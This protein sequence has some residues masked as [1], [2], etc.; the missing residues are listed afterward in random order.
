MPRARKGS[1][2]KPEMTW[3]QQANRMLTSNYLDLSSRHAVKQ[4]RGLKG[5]ESTGKIH[6]L[7]TLKKYE[8]SLAKAGTWI[9]QQFGVKR[10]NHITTQQAKAYLDYRR[11]EVGQKQLS[12]DRIALERCRKVGTLDR[13]L[14]EVKSEKTGRAYKP[15]QIDRIAKRQAPHNRLA[16]KI[17]YAAGLRAKELQTLKRAEDG[18]PSHH[19]QWR[20]DRFRGRSGERYLVVGK[21][22]LVREVLIPSDLARDLEKR[23]L[24]EPRT[25]KDRDLIYH[26]RYDIGGG[27]AWSKSVSMASKRELG[28][29]RGAHGLRHTYTQERLKEM[30]NQGYSYQ[31][32]KL[33]LSQEL[34]H[35]RP[36]V[37]NTYLR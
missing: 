13:V 22:G 30:Q 36:D 19:R 18:A 33:V 32:A 37:V 15:Q 1:T 25:L 6:A 8:L 17:A 29:S 35:F 14:S 28:W 9:Q 26:T 2:P 4:S 11:S 10:F 34:G 21:G 20:D 5:N 7:A 27:K 31:E 16:T 23:R 3:R 12:A 24:D